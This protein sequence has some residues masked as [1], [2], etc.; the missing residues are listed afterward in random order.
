MGIEA[1]SV[2]LSARDNEV[3][4]PLGINCMRQIAAAGNVVW[5]ARTM[6]GADVLRTDWKY[7]PVRR[8]ALYIEQ[9]VYRGTQWAVF[10]PNDA[11]LWAHVKQS[12]ADFLIGLF[13]Q[14][15]FQGEN[16]ESAY[17]VKCGAETITQQ[18]IDLGIL[19]I[20]IGFAPLQP[21]EFVV[22]RIQQTCV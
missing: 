13:R 5:G 10:E 14:G 2:D 22:L 1:L 7:V 12:V 21:A 8:L 20:E 3:L 4:N 6:A 16:P 9:S 15:A 11:R 18:D 19:N 17:Y